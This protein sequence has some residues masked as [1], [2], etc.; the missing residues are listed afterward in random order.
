MRS[1]LP[2]LVLSAGVSALAPPAFASSVC[3]ANLVGFDVCVQGEKLKAE[4]T[5]ASVE[6]AWGRG[7]FQGMS[8]ER[9]KLTYH[10]VR[11]VPRAVL[12][13]STGADGTLTDPLRA[14]FEKTARTMVC[15]D[16]RLAAMTRLG[17]VF[18]FRIANADGTPMHVATSD[19]CP[20]P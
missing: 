16:P 1:Y 15:N 7:A 20:H 19:V 4:T 13:K 17:S 3:T 10:L 12:Q 11:P 14:Q 8:V 18:E 5:A 6:Q 9:N 2:A